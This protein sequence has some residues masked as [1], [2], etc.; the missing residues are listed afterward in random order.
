MFAT[1]RPV[2]EGT[3]NEPSGPPAWK[4]IPS[5]FIYGELDLNIPPAAHAFMAKR[6]GAIETI[7]VKGAF[8]CRDGFSSGRG[9]ANDQRAARLH[10]KN[11]P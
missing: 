1:Q 10:G 4:T 8:A 11:P 6:A 9:R 2:T 5:W 7:E 3:L